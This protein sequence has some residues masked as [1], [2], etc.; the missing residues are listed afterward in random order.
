M[1]SNR[2]ILAVTIDERV[3]RPPP[4]VRTNATAAHH[5]LH[6]VQLELFNFDQFSIQVGGLNGVVVAAG[7]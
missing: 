7:V 6:V 4:L 1:H 2:T 5:F 3:L